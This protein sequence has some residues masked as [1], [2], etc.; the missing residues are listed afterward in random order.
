QEY[1]QSLYKKNKYSSRAIEGWK[2]QT[3]LHSNIHKAYK[4]NKI[5]CIILKH[6]KERIHTCMLIDRHTEIGMQFKIDF[7]WLLGATITVSI[8][9]MYNTTGSYLMVKIV[10]GI[11][12][13]LIAL[14]PRSCLF[15]LWSLIT[16]YQYSHHVDIKDIRYLSY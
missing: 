2:Q 5:K 3:G 6:K 7:M 13:R 1:S 15:L 4:K 11:H 16:Y 9:Y 8:L 10:E 14:G 12:R